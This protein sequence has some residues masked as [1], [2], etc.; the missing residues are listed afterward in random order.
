MLPAPGQGALA[1]VC[2]EDDPLA[3]QA[4]AVTDHATTRACVTAE[5]QFLRELMGGCTMPIGALARVEGEEMQFS[6]NVMTLDGREEVRVDLVFPLE[7][8]DVAG[9]EAAKLAF[10]KGAGAILE[11]LRGHGEP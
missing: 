2:R 1:V 11:K 3:I 4:A 5:R 6:G 9:Q 10:Q 8:F 7:K